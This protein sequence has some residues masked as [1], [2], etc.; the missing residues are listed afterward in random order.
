[1]K[2]LLEK[3]AEHFL[4]AEARMNTPGTVEGNWRFRLAPGALTDALALRLD[5]L[6][7]RHARSRD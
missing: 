3:R 7:R 6:T 2:V 1:M 5:G 4:G